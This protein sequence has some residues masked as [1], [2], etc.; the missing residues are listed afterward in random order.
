MFKNRSTVWSLRVV[1]DNRMVQG[2]LGARSLF[3]SFL[4]FFPHT[5]IN[6][7]RWG[8]RFRP[9]PRPVFSSLMNA[10]LRL[11][12]PMTASHFF[13]PFFFPYERISSFFPSVLLPLW[14][15]LIVLLP[16]WA[17]LFALLPLWAHLLVLSYRSSSPMSASLRPSSPMSASPRSFSPMSAP[18]RS[19]LSFFFPYERISSFFFPYERISSFF[20]SVLFPLWAHLFV[21]F[22]YSL[23]LA[24]LRADP[25]AGG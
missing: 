18:P 13:L 16:L 11:S 12:S 9:R 25:V 15:D 17:H 7:L 22:L 3:L 4:F 2:R 20:P 24:L 6:C 1:G 10:S 5:R 8:G 14:A 21:L 19:F 23:S